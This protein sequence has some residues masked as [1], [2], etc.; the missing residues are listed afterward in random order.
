[1]PKITIDWGWEEAFNKFGF[2]DGDGEV[3]TDSVV[4][5]IQAKGY[6]VAHQVWGMHNDTIYEIKRAD[7]TVIYP[8][9]SKP[10]YRVGYDNPRDVL[11]P[12]LVAHLDKE[13][14]D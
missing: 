14:P 12:D 8:P 3:M 1:M 10:N 6:R 11:P 7:G 4:A 13:F 2:G 9:P 5:A